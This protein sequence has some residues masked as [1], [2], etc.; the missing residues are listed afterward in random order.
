MLKIG[1]LVPSS[2]S[3]VYI[4]FLTATQQNP[5]SVV[6]VVLQTEPSSAAGV[7]P[8]SQSRVPSLWVLVGLAP[9]SSP[10]EF[11]MSESHRS[12]P[13]IGQ[14]RRFA[15]TWHSKGSFGKKIASQHIS[16][17]PIWGKHSC[18]PWC[19]FYFIFWQLLGSAYLAIPQFNLRC[20]ELGSWDQ[21]Q[22]CPKSPS[23]D[24]LIFFCFVLYRRQGASVNLIT[25]RNVR[26]CASL[27]PGVWG[28]AAGTGVK[29]FP[30]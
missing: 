20:L 26:L 12:A 25:N 11:S 19:L 4:G 2:F 3:R 1:A 29:D 30:H 23:L 6:V 8:L 14:N 21:W 18:C 28:V 13:Q 5:V 22:L 9:P 10:R 17:L 7:P 15:H 27:E 16:D 24:K